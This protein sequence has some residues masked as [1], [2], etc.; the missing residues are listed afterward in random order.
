MAF[1]VKLSVGV[2]KIVSTSKLGHEV[3]ASGEPPVDLS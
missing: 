1:K 2:D 3:M